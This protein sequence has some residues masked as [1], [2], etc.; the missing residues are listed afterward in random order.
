M[1]PSD[2]NLTLVGAGGFKSRCVLNTVRFSEYAVNLVAQAYWN[3]I[4][5][6]LNFVVNALAPAHFILNCLIYYRMSYRTKKRC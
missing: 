5:E 2:L 1:R 6:A 4:D 3:M